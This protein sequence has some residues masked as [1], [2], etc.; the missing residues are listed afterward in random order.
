MIRVATHADIPRILELGE[1]LHSVSSYADIAFDRVKVSALMAQIINGA[2]VVFLSERDGVVV[3]GIA[4]GVTE[5]WFSSTERLAFDYSFFIE[6]ESRSGITAMKLLTAFREWARLN[7]ARHL[8][9][10]ITTGLNVE[11]TARLYRAFGLT[12]LGPLFQ[13]EL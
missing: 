7:G 2:G 10:G 3:G 9:M 13:M 12:E 5:H 11:S 1:R 4:G 8:R 6:P